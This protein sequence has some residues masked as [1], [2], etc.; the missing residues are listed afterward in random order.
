MLRTTSQLVSWKSLSRDSSDF[1]LNLDWVINFGKIPKLKCHFQY[2]ISRVY[3]SIT[4]TYNFS[5]WHWST[6]SGNIC[7]VSPLS[8]YNFFSFLPYWTLL[9]EITMHSPYLE[10]AIM[11]H[12][13]FL[14]SFHLFIHSIIY[15]IYLLLKLFHLWSV[16]AT[17]AFFAS[18]GLEC[19]LAF[20][21]SAETLPPPRKKNSWNH[22]YSHWTLSPTIL[23]YNF[24]HYRTSKIYIDYVFI[25]CI[26]IHLSLWTI[27]FLI[28]S[29]LFCM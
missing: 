1:F 6:A 5:W 23:V 26:L 18:F 13:K 28:I 4:M 8:G 15:I 20:H 22:P 29:Y 17:H 9:K 24:S 14:S 21:D 16:G 2:L 19:I 11:F 7:Q 3:I 12:E 10:V 25:H 27:S